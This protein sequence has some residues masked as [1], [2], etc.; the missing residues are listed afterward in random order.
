MAQSWWQ[1]ATSRRSTSASLGAGEQVRTCWY[2][3]CGG[4]I[5]AC[6]LYNAA[7]PCQRKSAN[8]QAVLEAVR[9]GFSEAGGDSCKLVEA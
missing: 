2:D 7:L 8:R 6:L 5:A 9:T 1:E 4:V 3:C